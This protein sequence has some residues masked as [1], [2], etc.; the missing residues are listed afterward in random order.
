MWIIPRISCAALA[1][2]LLL[3]GCVPTPT[4]PSST[5]K[6]TATP[7]FASEAEALAAATKAYAAYQ[8]VLDQAFSTY[9]TSRL[10]QVSSG[11]ALSKAKA[12][13]MEYER[14]GKHQTGLAAIDKVS[15]VNSPLD[16]PQSDSFDAQAYLC[17]DLSDV[18]VLGGDGKSVV[19]PG[20]DRRF[21][22]VASFKLSR[23]S[24]ALIVDEDESWSGANFC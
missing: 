22:V 24:Q 21:P 11:S 23:S 13:A 7:V 17:L 10:T 19:P 2:A 12:S 3:S 6:P 9:D 20:S 8:R 4:P 18:D 16:S 1:V 14:A 15:F 5:P